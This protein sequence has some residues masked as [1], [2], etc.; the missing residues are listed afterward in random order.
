MNERIL[1]I[2]DDDLMRTV[3][4]K[5]LTQAGYNIVQASNGKTG[6]GLVS[7]MK[8]DLILCDVMMPELDGYDVLQML[9]KN[10]ETA[11]IPFIFLTLYN[12]EIS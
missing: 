3:T 1:I 12:L 9:S 10:Q 11:S 2:D 5:V 8:P 4:T 6:V 7:Q